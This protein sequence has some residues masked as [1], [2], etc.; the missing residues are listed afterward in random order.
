MITSPILNNDEYDVIIPFINDETDENFAKNDN[1]F[2]YNICIRSKTNKGK[3]TVDF[4]DSDMVKE[5]SKS[6]YFKS[7]KSV[8]KTSA[9]FGVVKSPCDGTIMY[10]CNTEKYKDR[11]SMLIYIDNTQ[12]L[13]FNNLYY[14]FYGFEEGSKV[15]TGDMLGLYYI[16][17]GNAKNVEPY[18]TVAYGTNVPSRSPIRAWDMTFYKHDPTYIIQGLIDTNV[19]EEQM[20][21]PMD[22][23]FESDYAEGWH[24][25]PEIQN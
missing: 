15:F 3:Y 14:I 18:L 19:V 13:L 12:V 11:H 24:S 1:R 7:L 23:G 6:T 8:A 21:I 10:I 20:N 25:T 22:Q 2:N 9:T 4:K 16:S 5:L 17:K